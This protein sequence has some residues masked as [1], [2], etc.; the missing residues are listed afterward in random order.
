MRNFT[1][2]WATGTQKGAFATLGCPSWMLGV[3]SG[4]AGDSG[5]GKWDVANVPADGGNWGG[6]WLA[7]PAQ[8]KHPAE[9][10]K[11]ADYLT[12]TE[13]EASI[14]KDFGNMPSNSKALADPSVQNA[15]NPFFSDAPIGQ[16]FAKSAAALQ[17]VYLGIKHAQVKN[18]IES[19]VQGIDDRSIPFDTSW[20]K[21]QDDAL[22]AAG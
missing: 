10:A 2:E 11:V 22:K 21:L 12:S 13:V 4:N 6:S 5:K 8:T 1:P 16:I 19:V 9:A 14:F 17:P 20:Q 18:A 3:V 15:T 7:V